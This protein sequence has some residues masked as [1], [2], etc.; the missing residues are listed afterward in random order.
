MS[1]TITKDEVVSHKKKAIKAIGNTFEAFINS[2]EDRH[3][4]KADL[5]AYWIESFSSY[6]LDE[7]KYDYSKIPKFKRG[8]VISVNFGFNVG[9]EHGGRHYAIVLDNDNKQSSRVITVIPLSSGS[10]DNTNER[11]VYLGNELYDKLKTK[12]DK[13][14]EENDSSMKEMTQMLE[15]IRKILSAEE[16]TSN[17]D[18]E[19]M[20]SFKEIV[21]NLEKRVD[22][23]NEEKKMLEN[24]NK[25]ISKL[26][27]GS[28][29]LMEQ[30]T[31]ISKMRIYKPK[32]S[33]DLLYGIKFSDGAMDK[34]NDKL[35]ELYVFSK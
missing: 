19:K 5:L 1:R 30:I 33:R 24:Y 7:E 18:S 14:C 31:T 8:E 28:R 23:L 27:T 2:P 16:E 34:I 9:S 35:K 17:V 3:L 29:A 11:D 6:I 20:E 21:N 15:I 13:L 32:T 25:E 12:Y 26:K 22:I 4:K 10:S